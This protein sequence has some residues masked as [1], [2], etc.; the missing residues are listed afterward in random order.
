M[1][2]SLFNKV[3]GLKTCNFIKGD[4]N[5]GVFLW[6]LTNFL[7]TSILKNTCE[8]LLLELSEAALR[9]II[10]RSSHSQVISRIV[11][12]KKL[13]K[14][15]LLMAKLFLMCFLVSVLRIAFSKHHLA[16]ASL[17]SPRIPSKTQGKIKRNFQAT[18]GRQNFQSFGQNSTP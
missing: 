4:S 15:I 18:T 8:R 9:S 6:M 10:N 16:T 2:E 14:P 17:S 7:R 1:L 11:P 3:A 12:L 13:S 5:T